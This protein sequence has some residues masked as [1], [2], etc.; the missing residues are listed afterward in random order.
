MCLKWA[1]VMFKVFSLSVLSPSTY[2]LCAH[3]CKATMRL[4]LTEQTQGH[5][6][7]KPADS[8]PFSL[9]LKPNKD[10]FVQVIDILM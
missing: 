2:V 8:F 9:V 1:S 10:L 3:G 7:R 5:G 6:R 4:G